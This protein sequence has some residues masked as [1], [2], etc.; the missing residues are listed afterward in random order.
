MIRILI[1]VM[2]LVCWHNAALAQEFFSNLNDV[3]LMES[4]A[5]VPEAAVVFDKMEGR[6]VRA[7]AITENVETPEIITFYNQTLPQL[8]WQAARMPQTYIRDGEQLSFQI[9]EESGKKIVIFTIEP[10]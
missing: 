7:T 8:G 10:L 3:P 5:E 1:T 6:I 4:M 9:Q 2:G